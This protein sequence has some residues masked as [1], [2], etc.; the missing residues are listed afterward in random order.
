MPS[1]TVS[2][3]IPTCNRAS[4]LPV[5]IRSALGQTFRDL[6]VIVVDDDSE[7]RTSEVLAGIS[8]PRLH[9]LRQ[10]AR[11]GGAAARN[12]G[13]A[14]AR[15]EYIAFLDDDDEWFPE[16]LDLQIDLFR[17]S[18]M[19][20]G[21]VY[22]SYVTV[23]RE[24][25]RVTGRKIAERSGDL[26]RDLLVRNVI[27]GTS[28]VVVRRACFEKAGLF[29]ER[30]PSFQDY[31]LWIRISR[32]FHFDYVA[33]DL[34]SYYVHARKIWNDPD[35]LSR[36]IDIMV[37]KHGTSRAL[38]R[39]LAGQS[40]SVGLQYC[41]RGEGSKGR[42]ALFRSIR[43]A[44]LSARPYLNLVLSLFGAA[45]FRSVHEAKGRLWSLFL[46]NGSGPGRKPVH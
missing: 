45:A 15:G 36:G 33:R 2:V 29:D 37:Q 17:Q 38:R 7:D 10:E 34:L 26:S 14:R 6:E 19:Q 31:D 41:F 40:L 42:R 13:I 35:A 3:I 9:Y 24:S 5:A 21:V 22:G 44:P 27:G 8:D 12:A 23:D 39:N 43:L 28:S 46:A 20:V 11:R 30:L 32:D 1:P 25:G 18:P 16:K 4:L